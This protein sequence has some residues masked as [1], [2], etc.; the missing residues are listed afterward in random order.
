MHGYLLFWMS[1]HSE[2]FWRH[3]QDDFTPFPNN[4]IFFKVCQSVNWLTSLLKLDKCRDISCSGWAIFGDIPRM[5]SH[6]LKIIVNFLYVCHSISCLTSLLKLDKCRD[7]ASSGWD[8]SQNFF[9][10]IPGMLVHY[11]QIIL[12]FLYVWQSVI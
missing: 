2:N 8:I 9:E 10:D 1:Y 7:I 6:I 11:F 4:S 3:S 5:F 12:N